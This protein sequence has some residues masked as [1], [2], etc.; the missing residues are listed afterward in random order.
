MGKDE[1]K[2][3]QAKTGQH[4]MPAVEAM[5]CNVT[6]PTLRD[7]CPVTATGLSS[8]SASLCA[9]VARGLYGHLSHCPADLFDLPAVGRLRQW[10]SV[11]EPAIETALSDLAPY[12]VIGIEQAIAEGAFAE[13]DRLL[14]LLARMDTEAPALPR[15]HE[16][17]RLAR[18]AELASQAEILAANEAPAA[19]VPAAAIPAPT[20]VAVPAQASPRAT[21]PT[22][23][24]LLNQVPARFPDQAL[25]RRLEGSVQLQ[26]TIAA[27]GEV[28]GVEVIESS[29]EVFHREAL[30]AVR[31]WRYEPAAIASTQRVIVHFRL[32]P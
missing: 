2:Q 8:R 31:R 23:R 5:R 30:L 12:V 18:E 19:L 4:S 7:T 32:P 6:Q 16:S 26:L 27:S 29:H 15:L 9:R 17:L 13:A 11:P 3:C 25:R 24:A 14:G 10:A 22:Q 1:I 28:T 21:A 20:S